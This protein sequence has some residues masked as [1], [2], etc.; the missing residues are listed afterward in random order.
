MDRPLNERLKKQVVHTGL[1]AV[2]PVEDDAECIVCLCNFYQ[3]LSWGHPVVHEV[4]KSERTSLRM[5]NRAG[6]CGALA[7]AN[8][9]H[10]SNH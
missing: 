5:D 8:F 3:A 10:Y 6:D 1:A 4:V 9:C 7:E 2:L